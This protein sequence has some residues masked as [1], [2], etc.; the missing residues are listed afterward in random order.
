LTHS[1]V[2]VPIDDAPVWSIVCFVVGRR[3]RGHGV[4]TALLAAAID[5]ARGH[6]ATMLEAYPVDVADGKRVA[7]ANVYR[8]TLSMFERAGFQV[9]ARRQWN[10]ASPVRPIVRLDLR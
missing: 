7:S 8:G 10:T 5:Y 9:V 2:L 3:S 4:A 1:A 6:G